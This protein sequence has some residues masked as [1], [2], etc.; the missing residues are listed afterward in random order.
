[1]CNFCR[2]HYPLPLNLIDP[3]T[4]PENHSNLVESLKSE[5]S[6]LK[7]EREHQLAEISRVRSLFESIL[8]V[9]QCESYSQ[10][11]K[12]NDRLNHQLKH[13]EMDSSKSKSRRR[14]P[15]A[16]ETIHQ[17]SK[18]YVEIFQLTRNVTKGPLL[19]S[20]RKTAREESPNPNSKLRTLLSELLHALDTTDT[21]CFLS[22]LKNL[23]FIQFFYFLQ[24]ALNESTYSK[25]SPH[26]IVSQMLDLTMDHDID[27][28]RNGSSYRKSRPNLSSRPLPATP[29]RPSNGTR[30]TQSNQSLKE[31]NHTTHSAPNLYDN[32]CFPV[33]KISPFI[34]IFILGRLNTKYSNLVRWVLNQTRR[35]TRKDP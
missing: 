24:P 21:V 26:D 2:V 7:L 12:E 5:V 1:M 11:L 14:K 19:N 9:Y 10:L 22:T 27:L 8:F 17:P 23:I 32:F 13:L 35:H 18:T 6:K 16:S 33:I 28:K 29:P 31:R 20:N 30:R 4:E 3:F 15:D 34:I 25:P